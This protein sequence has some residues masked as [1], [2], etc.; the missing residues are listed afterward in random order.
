[1]IIEEKIIDA[2]KV[3]FYDDY[4]ENKED[5]K[6]DIEVLIKRLLDDI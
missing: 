5:V 4:I 1:M 6:K 3:K 2:T